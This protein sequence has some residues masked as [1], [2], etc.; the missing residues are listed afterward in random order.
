MHNPYN[1]EKGVQGHF[2]RKSFEEKKKQSEALESV[3]SK[4]SSESKQS[5]VNSVTLANNI[6][7]EYTEPKELNGA[8]VSTMYYADFPQHTYFVSAA[9]PGEIE[10]EALLEF[11]EE[12]KYDTMKHI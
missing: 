8:F 3:E 10:T 11:L 9:T 4:Q 5:K 7:V 2:K 12:Y 6:I 1:N